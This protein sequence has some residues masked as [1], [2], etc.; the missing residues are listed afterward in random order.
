MTTAKKSGS[1]FSHQHTRSALVSRAQSRACAAGTWCTAMGGNQ[2]KTAKAGKPG[3]AA[4]ASRGVA[5]TA[6]IAGKVLNCP[7]DWRWC[8]TAAAQLSS[9]LVTHHT[10]SARTFRE[11]LGRGPVVFEQANLCKAQGVPL[12]F[13]LA[14][15]RKGAIQPRRVQSFATKQELEGKLEEESNTHVRSSSVAGVGT[16]TV[17][18]SSN[19]PGP[20][21]SIVFIG[22]HVEYSDEGQTNEAFRLPE[23]WDSESTVWE[24]R[25]VDACTSCVL[26]PPPARCLSL[27]SGCSS[28]ACSP[29]PAYPPPCKAC[30]N[31]GTGVLWRQ[32]GWF[33]GAFGGTEREL[34]GAL[35]QRCALHFVLL[36]AFHERSYAGLPHRATARAT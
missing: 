36:A 17:G 1:A 14:T 35:L 6:G 34:G 10:K 9:A 26:T 24:T 4:A 32:N 15:A 5:N 25:T 31:A 33:V 22:L 21:G 18:G 7:G 2:S 11:H 13:S 19:F 16:P 12:W 3:A 23:A 29:S 27:C 30:R 20:P 28:V 8:T